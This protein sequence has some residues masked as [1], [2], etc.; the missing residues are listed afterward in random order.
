[1]YKGLSE[2]PIDQATAAIE[3]SDLSPPLQAREDLAIRFFEHLRGALTAGKSGKTVKCSYQILR[4]LYAWADKNNYEMTATTVERVFLDWT[5]WLLDNSRGN[6]T[7]LQTAFGRATRIATVIDGVLDRDRRIMSFSRLRKK[8]SPK[9]WGKAA[10]KINFE[11]LFEMGNVLLDLCESL[12]VENVKGDLPVMLKFRTGETIE[13]WSKLI[14]PSNLKGDWHLKGS[15]LRKRKAWVEDRSWRTRHPLMNLRIEAELLIFVAQTQSNLAQTLDMKNGRFAYQSYSGGYHCK[16][17]FKDRRQG[18]VEFNVYSE[19]RAHF[20][21]YLAWRNELYPEDG[22]LFPLSS[23]FHRAPTT[24]P[25]FRGVRNVLEKLNIPYT[26]PRQLRLSKI[27][28]LLRKTRDPEL[29]AEMGQHDELTLLLNYEQPN[30]QAA[31]AELTRYHQKND[32][33]FSPPGPGVCVKV[34]PAGRPEAPKN[35]PKPDCVNPAGCLFCDHHRDIEDL[36]HVWSLTTY[37]Y[38]KSLELAAHRPTGATRDKHPAEMTM[39]RVTEKLELF[40]TLPKMS[41]WVDESAVRIE[42]GNY[43]PKWAGFVTLMELRM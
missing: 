23:H 17:I 37:R 33:A 13:H 5:D 4:S 9:N 25:N 7:G 40:K 30:H 41:P 16:K 11:N 14:P 36:D 18:E 15:S 28:W 26:S 19:Y 42:E 39:E 6:S 43:H 3:A 35:L 8:S 32:P 27:N 31:A 1:M 22:L 20:E 29:T 24:S 34:K 38:L 10:D 21:K 12:S 2:L